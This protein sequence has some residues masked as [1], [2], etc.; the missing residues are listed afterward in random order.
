MSKELL[1]SN[2]STIFATLRNTE[3]Y[4]CKPRNDLNCMTQHYGP[5]TWFL[6][7]SPSEW[8]WE[9]LGEYIREV[10][11][12]H[13]ASLSVS[14]L[15]VRDPVST[16]RF[17]DNK[18][19]AMLDFIRSKDHPIGEVTHYFWR[20][21]YQGRGIQHFHLLIWI[22]NAPIFGESTIEEVSKFI[23]QHISCTIPDQNISPLLYRRVDTH[24]RH[25]HNDY[26]LRSKKVGRKVIRRCRFGFPRPVTETLNIRDVAT[27]IAGRKQLK[28]KSRLY[29]LPRTDNEGNINDYNPVLL[30]AWE[31]NMDIQFIGEK[32]SLL[33]W[34]VTKYMN[35]AGKSE[36]S[37]NILD[38]KDNKN[39]SLA[40][41]LWNIALR[42]TNNR[43][44]G[45]LEAADTLLGIPLYGTDRNTTIR[46]LDV[47]QIRYKN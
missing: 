22:K 3:Q 28:H 7:L 35:K 14:A 8:L 13:D 11:E 45:A 38:S 41:H 32:S 43:E 15:V 27:S 4:W 20:R 39:K 25:I 16:S 44:C 40:S 5:A 1:E 33:T 18:F 34:Y 42:F 21:E 19:R 2:L 46:W 12:W 37:E 26:C 17:L 36:L 6:T 47:N 10:N 9:D 29:D 23:S 30:T 24:Q 31:G